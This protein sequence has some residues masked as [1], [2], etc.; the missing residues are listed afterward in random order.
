MISGISICWLSSSASRDFRL[1]RSGLIGK[2]GEAIEERRDE[3]GQLES[4]N[5]GKPLEA[6]KEEM[7]ASADC[8]RFMAGAARTPEGQAAAEY[9]RGSTSMI[10][11][12]P[13]GVCAQI[14]PWN[15]PLMMAS[16]K[17]APALAAGNTVVLKPSELTPLTTLRMAEL[18]ADILPQG[19]L[20]IVSGY[21]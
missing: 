20:N 6:A 8:F 1:A 3:L 15:Y 17:I 13:I 21:G 7:D 14:T 16:W 2:R 19:V 4:L 12:E 18:A 9:V 11:R 10:R 5:V